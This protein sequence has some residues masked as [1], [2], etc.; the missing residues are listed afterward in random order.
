MVL[1]LHFFI[2]EID[3]KCGHCPL[4]WVILEDH[5]RWRPE[6]GTLSSLCGSYQWLKFVTCTLVYCLAVK[7]PNCRFL[8]LKDY[9]AVDAIFWGPV[10]NFPWNVNSSAIG[11][12]TNVGLLLRERFCSW[13]HKK[14]PFK[15]SRTKFILWFTTYIMFNAHTNQKRRF[16]LKR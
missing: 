13:S 8:K 4:P 12:S 11:K 16:L 6:L 15:C 1:E 9:I 7:S 2:I 5:L 3:L 10:V 14:L